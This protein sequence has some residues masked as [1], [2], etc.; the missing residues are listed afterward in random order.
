MV[1]VGAR[2]IEKG[3]GTGGT[4]RKEVEGVVRA[5]GFVGGIENF[6]ASHNER[7]KSV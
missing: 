3:N 5:E 6:A 1:E 4:G 2:G 7:E